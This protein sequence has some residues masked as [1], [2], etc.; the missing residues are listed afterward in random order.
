MPTC[1]K[2]KQDFPR[3][4][5]LQWFVDTRIGMLAA[6]LLLAGGAMAAQTGAY[7]VSERLLSRTFDFGDHL[8]PLLGYL[9]LLAIVAI[10]VWLTAP[11]AI[12]SRHTTAER[13]SPEHRAWMR[14]WPPVILAAVLLAIFMVIMLP[15][16]LSIAFH[17]NGNG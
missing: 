17:H 10:V 3:E 15:A 5:W 16:V 2:C 14:R 1:P 7:A 6:W 8:Q 13:A 4:R 9:P 11:D 12:H